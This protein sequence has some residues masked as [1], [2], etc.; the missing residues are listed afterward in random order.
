MKLMEGEWRHGTFTEL[1]KFPLENVFPLN[2]EVL[3]K[4][5]GFS[6]ADLCYMGSCLAAY[7]GLSEIDVKPGEIV[8]V[9]PATGKFGGAA[10]STV[11]A[12]GATAI[13]AGRNKAV[14]KSLES[15]YA[16]TGRIKT[17]ALTGDQAKDTEAFFILSPNRAGADA[18][19][20]FSP[21]AAAK[22]T[23]ITAAI[24]AVKSFGRVALM[25][26]IKGNIELLY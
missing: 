7:G 19:I 14:L 8:I 4:Q 5:R 11:I 25:G 10:V 9:A 15:T 24:G 1:A 20:D 13:A 26:G 3:V 23:H 18:Y 2:E 6:F 17:L 21:P 22:S 16:A 12:M